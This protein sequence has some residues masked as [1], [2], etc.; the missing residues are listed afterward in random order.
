[1]RLFEFA[2]SGDRRENFYSATLEFADNWEENTQSWGTDYTPGL[3]KSEADEL[4]Y[5]ANQFLKGLLAG[6]Q[7]FFNLDTLI[8]DELS[9]YWKDCGLDPRVI[10]KLFRDNPDI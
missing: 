7:A 5:V 4:R 9:E 3:A 8:R 2:P 1:M 6:T 10:Y